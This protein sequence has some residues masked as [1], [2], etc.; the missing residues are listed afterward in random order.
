MKRAILALFLVSSLAAFGQG[1]GASGGRPA[2]AGAPSHSMGHST[3]VGRPAEVGKPSTAGQPST[4]PGTVSSQAHQQRALTDAQINSGSFKML[5]EKTGMSSEQLQQL[6]ASSGARNYGQ[7]V[8]AVVVSKNLNLDT[9][10]VLEGMKTKSLGKTLKDLGVAEQ[11]ANAE[12]KKANQ[13][14]KAANRKKS[15]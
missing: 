6:Y 2:G 8:S 3:D 9:N 15:S 12:I 4:S 7:F 1:K 10:A 13:E 14:M 5:Q 11:T